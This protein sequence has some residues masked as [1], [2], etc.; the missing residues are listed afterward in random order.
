MERAGTAW[1]KAALT[2]ALLGATM[3]ASGCAAF[4]EGENSP[5][6]FKERVKQSEKEPFPQLAQVPDVPEAGRPESEWRTIEDDVTKAGDAVAANPRSAPANM[7]PEEIAAFE[8]EARRQ[9]EP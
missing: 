9:A 7:T 3:G 1:T 4:G 2:A 8:A 5:G 6:W